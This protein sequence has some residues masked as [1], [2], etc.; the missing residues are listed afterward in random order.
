MVTLASPTTALLGSRTVPWMLPVEIVVCAHSQLEQA[1]SAMATRTATLLPEMV[2]PKRFSLD[3]RLPSFPQT[4]LEISASR[5]TKQEE[6]RCQQCKVRI[7]GPNN[8]SRVVSR[9]NTD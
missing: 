1:S 3:I 9:R 4:A 7:R 2:K 5:K 8:G 6:K